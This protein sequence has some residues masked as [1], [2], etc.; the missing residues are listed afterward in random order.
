MLHRHTFGSAEQ[1][2]LCFLHGFMGSSADWAPLVQGLEDD[3]YCLAVDLPGH[4]QSLDQPEE[5]YSVAGATEAV[6]EVFDAEGV[7]SCVLVGYSMGGR[8]ALSLTLRH[9]NRV[10]RL[11][12]ESASPGLRTKAERADRREVDAKRAARIEDDLEAFLADWYRLPLFDSLAQHGLVDE[13]VRT[14]CGNDPA[15]LARALRGMS[16]GRQTSFWERLDE[17]ACPTL[18]LTGAL[19]DK[20]AAITEETTARIEAARRVV[21][22]GGGHNVHAERPTAFTEALTQFL[23]ATA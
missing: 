6:V 17:I 22:P 2:T 16:P 12:L 4:G 9:P 7:S 10:G 13:M 14:R 5:A 15:E 19:D 23:A 1:P 11:G 3:F 8:V 20:Y 21:I 18:V